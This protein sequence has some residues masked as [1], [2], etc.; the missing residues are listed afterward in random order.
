M[1]RDLT[2]KERL[3]IAAIGCCFVLECGLNMMGSYDFLGGRDGGVKALAIAFGGALIAF[4]GAW[5]GH[6]GAAKGVRDGWGFWPGLMIFVACLVF[7]FS[8]FVGWRVLGVSFSDGALKREVAG[9]T[10]SDWRSER[11]A[12]GVTRPV[13]AIE[14]DIQ[15]ELMRTSKSFP[16]G[17]GPATMRLRGELATAKKAADLEARIAKAMSGGNVVAAGAENAIAERLLFGLDAATAQLILVVTMC[18]MIGFFANFGLALLEINR[19]PHGPGGGGRMPHGFAQAG[20]W[21]DPP[22]M[23]R[24]VA[25]DV[26]HLSL[27]APAAGH[28]SSTAPVTINIG[29]GGAVSTSQPAQIETGPQIM[30]QSAAERRRASRVAERVVPP[31]VTVQGQSAPRHD[32]PALPADAPPIDRSRVQR[33]LTDAERPVADVMLAFRAACV[34]DAPGGLVAVENLYRRYQHWAGERA[35]STEL[36]LKLFPEVTGVCIE[37]LGGFPHAREVALRAGAALRVA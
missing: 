8:Q 27:P 22:G 26:P 11:R 16:D 13:A 24:A 31:G 29:P 17:N 36:F 28:A 34:V 6:E 5:C 25:R 23:R 19:G 4:L 14:A 9:Q 2:V 1:T 37:R 3:V 10:L 30:V 15:R 32:L 33:E 20:E 12:I 35:A 18:A 7:L 21:H